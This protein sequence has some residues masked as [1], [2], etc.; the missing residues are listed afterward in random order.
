MLSPSFPA[1]KCFKAHVQ[2]ADLALSTSSATI[3]GFADVR[4]FDLFI[5]NW[6]DPKATGFGWAIGPTFLLPTGKVWAA[7]HARQ[8]GC[9]AAAGTEV[10]QI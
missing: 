10:F 2:A 9:A 1:N 8:V 6:P 5:S 7:P 4:L 3:T